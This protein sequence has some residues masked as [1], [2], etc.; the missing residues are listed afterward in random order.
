MLNF[1][2]LF[3]PSPDLNPI[4]PGKMLDQVIAVRAATL[5][6]ESGFKRQNSR[7]WTRQADRLIHI[8]NVQASQWNQ[9]S[10]ASFT[11]NLAVLVPE[12]YSAVEGSKPPSL[13]KEYDG[14]MRT[15]L[16]SLKVGGTESW[17]SRDRWYDYGPQTDVLK[18]G[19]QLAEDI[20]KKGLPYFDRMRD[21]AS[22]LHILESRALNP[23]LPMNK[24]AYAK[25]VRRLLAVEQA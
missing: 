24:D 2:S 10:K 11:V 25:E 22:L 13:P 21:L 17:R 8:L 6:K 20:E 16:S 7:T 4:D 9:A 23:G 19:T 18:L 14:I 1:L 5:L 12:A 15:R 3:K